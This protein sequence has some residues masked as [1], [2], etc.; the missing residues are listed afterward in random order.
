MWVDQGARGFSTPP[1]VAG[2]FLAKLSGDVL[3]CAGFGMADGG[4]ARPAAVD[5]AGGDDGAGPAAP[6]AGKGS[7]PAPVRNRFPSL[8]LDDLKDF[9]YNHKVNLDYPGLQCVYRAQVTGAPVFIVRNFLSDAEC[10]VCL[11]KCTGRLLLSKTTRGVIRTSS[12]VRV[13]REETPGLHQ[14]LAN[15]TARTVDS[16]E[17][18]KIIRWVDTIGIF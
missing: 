4:G 1:R 13:A 16:L 5:T 15:L 7:S 17:S 2:L 14:R 10:D 18:A 6:P 12:H 8:P 11:A 3:A 9:P